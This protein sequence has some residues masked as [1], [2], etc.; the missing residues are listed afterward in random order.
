[1]TT[2]NTNP[3]RCNPNTAHEMALW[4]LNWSEDDAGDQPDSNMI[5]AFEVTSDD[6]NNADGFWNALDRA[7]PR[8][9]SELRRGR[10]VV[11][12]AVELADIT[13]LAGFRSNDAPDHAPHPLMWQSCWTE[14]DED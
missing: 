11:M 4:L 10:A 3:A 8:Y 1:M 6:E 2:L 7:Y 12:S 9:A 13:H 5:E 14:C